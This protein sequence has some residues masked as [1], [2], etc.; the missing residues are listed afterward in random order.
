MGQDTAAASMVRRIPRGSSR[1]R[2]AALTLLVGSGLILLA[3]GAPLDIGHHAGAPGL[4]AEA[5]GAAGHLV[6]LAGMVVTTMA[7]ALIAVLRQR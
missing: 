1:G 5:L 7:V 6:T 2:R 4:T 3:L